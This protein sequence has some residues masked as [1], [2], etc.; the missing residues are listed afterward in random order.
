MKFLSQT[1]DLTLTVETPDDRYPQTRATP[2]HRQP[3]HLMSKSRSSCFSQRLNYITARFSRWHSRSH[4][5]QPISSR[6]RRLPLQTRHTPSSQ[7]FSKE[8]ANETDTR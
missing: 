5:A 4:D 6:P 2:L 1:E 7:P 3:H 8:E